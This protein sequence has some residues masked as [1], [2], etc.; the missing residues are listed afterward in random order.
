MNKR[1]IG[2]AL[3]LCG[4]VGGV[5]EGWAGHKKAKKFDYDA[6]YVPTSKRQA[7]DDW[8]RS[9]KNPSD[10]CRRY[11]YG[12]A[13]LPRW[14]PLLPYLREFSAYWREVNQKA[15]L[16]WKKK[17][18]PTLAARSINK[19]PYRSPNKRGREIQ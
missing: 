16:A 17:P 14:T 2:V 1:V 12:A 11:T 9:H 15:Y 3:L 10:K 18:Y 7:K 4:L 8:C 5:T 6:Y 13:E 19:Y